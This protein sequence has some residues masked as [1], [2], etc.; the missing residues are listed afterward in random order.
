MGGRNYQDL[1]AWQK[2]MELVEIVYRCTRRLPKEE[3]YGLTN[4]LRRSAVSIPSNIAEGQ[5]RGSIKEFLHFLA[6]AHGSLREFETQLMIAAR[7]R[8]VTSDD[9]SRALELAAE[10][11]RLVT[12]LANSLRKR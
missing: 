11:G 10:V 5:G 9:L 4:Q 8:Y 3:M 2:A 7:L 12:G 6:I 1:L